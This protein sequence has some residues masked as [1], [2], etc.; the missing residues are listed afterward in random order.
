MAQ[1]V[2]MLVQVVSGMAFARALAVADYGTY[3]QTFQ[4]YDFVVPLLTLGLPSAIYY[5]LPGEAVRRKGIV[6]DNMLLLFLTGTIFSLF[7]IFG[8]TDLLAKRFN[9]PDL[10]RT[11]RWIIFYPLYT[12]PVLMASSVWVTQDKVKLNALYNLGTGL[13]LA[14]LLILGVSLT[15]YYE[16][17]ILIRIILPAIY[18]PFA[19]FLIFKNVPGQWDFPRV[20]SMWRM[21]RFSVPLG[22]ASIFGTLAIQ[23]SG[24][25]VSFLTSPE[26]YAIYANGAKEV[27]FISIVTGSISVVLLADMAKSIKNG[28]IEIALELFRKAARISASFLFPIMVFLMIFSESFIQIL[29]S[30]KYIE[31]VTPFRIYLFIIPIRIAY[32]GS[33]FIALG[34]T[35]TILLRSI[36]DLLLT[37]FF[38]YFF[39]L[40]LG[41]YGAALGLILTMFFWTVPFNLLS[42]SKSFKCKASYILP[43]DRLFRIAII[44]VISAVVPATV[45]FFK[46]NSIL[47]FMVAISIYFIIYSILSYRYNN[48]LR[49]IIDLYLKKILKYL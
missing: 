21:L 30:E 38:C 27:P 9:N 31:S 8:G 17:P 5:F 43:F 15:H 22:L 14:V 4:A 7:L 35:Q 33:A 19:I 1:G 10:S 25:I 44:S 40:W 20:S 28:D 24:V 16:S 39:V 11:L 32:Y 2:L 3:L 42:L 48:D 49:D 46:L 41:A 34:R 36:I 12:F 26:E 6:L 29:Y 23:L 47:E 13:V 18:F 37:A 45:L